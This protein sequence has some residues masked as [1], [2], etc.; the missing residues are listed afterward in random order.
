[1]VLKRSD[2]S[3]WMHYYYDSTSN[4]AWVL[5]QFNSEYHGGGS[6]VL[7]RL[8]ELKCED[9]IEL[10]MTSLDLNDVIGASKEL[11]E[12]EQNDKEDFRDRLITRM[13]QTD[14][15][16]SS[17]AERDRLRIIISKT[18]L[19][20]PMNRRNIVGKRFNEIKEDSEYYQ[21]LA[22]KAKDLLDDMEK[23]SS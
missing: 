18:N 6:P 22:F 1:M 15:V 7:K 2:E 4:E 13:L 8:P 5:T 10:A 17:S 16:N 19:L 20:D 11:A 14:V 3:G 9:L 23:Y 12:R 21:H